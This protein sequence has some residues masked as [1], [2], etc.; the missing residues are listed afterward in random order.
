MLLSD[1]HIHSQWSDG[2]HTIEEIVDLYGRRGF[3]VIAITDHVC[4]T[5][6]LMGRAAHWLNRSLTKDTFLTYIQDIEEQAFRAWKLYRMLVIPGVEITKNALRTQRSAHI[7]GLGVRHWVDPDLE[8]REI[9]E[10]IRAQ[11]AITVAAHPVFT[12]DPS[13]LPT[14]QLWRDKQNLCD[15][16]DCW[17]VASGAQL[18]DEVFRSGLPMLANSDLHHQKQIT[19]WKTLVAADCNEGSVLRSIKN[20][21]VSFGFYGGNG[22][23]E[24]LRLKYVLAAYTKQRHLDRGFNSGRVSWNHIGGAS[25]YVG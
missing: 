1:L 20:Q 14:L 21:D 11:G 10:S 9:L 7:L 6:S 22:V 3:R 2:R 16:I 18:F 23:H 19:S 15:L 13:Y 8:V 5:N 12:L 17:E 4:E 25:D 24:D